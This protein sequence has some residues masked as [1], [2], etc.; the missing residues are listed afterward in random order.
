MLSNRNTRRMSIMMCK[1]VVVR[2]SA[3]WLMVSL[4]PLNDV[5]RTH[6]FDSEQ[7]LLISHPDM[8][9]KVSE[10]NVKFLSGSFEAT[11]VKIIPLEFC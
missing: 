3:R 11:K 10:E 5:T 1:E 4:S 2:K 7:T 6:I 8:P 9:N